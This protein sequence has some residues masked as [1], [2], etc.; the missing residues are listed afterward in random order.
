M[1]FYKQALEQYDK[2]GLKPHHKSYFEIIATIVLL[3]ILL[4]M[5]FPAIKHI[6]QLNK[7]ITDGKQ[8][9][10]ALEDKL[11]ALDQARLN[12]ENV[13]PDLP[14]LDLALPVGSDVGGYIRTIE[15]MAANHKLRVVS[16]NFA[17]IPISKPNV[18]ETLGTKEFIFEVGFAGTFPRFTNFLKEFEEFIRTNSV[19]KVSV[20]RKRESNSRRIIIEETI[21]VTA[22]YQ[23]KELRTNTTLRG[24]R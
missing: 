1:T 9:R 18:Q 7:E 24:D 11:V 4:L 8:V 16:A 23:G 5:I 3:I 15:K 14:L 21:S 19:V 17:D 6:T 13:R 12:L 20:E 10:S 22:Y 2:I